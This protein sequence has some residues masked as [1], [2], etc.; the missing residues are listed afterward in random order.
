MDGLQ[1]CQ[2][3][4]MKKTLHDRHIPIIILTGDKTDLVHQAAIQVGAF[5]V[6]AKPVSAPTLREA[7]SAS[8]GFQL[9][10]PPVG[11]QLTD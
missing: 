8:V 4:R 7:I 10:E 9:A 1:F 3:I 2:R 6:L 5:T 11:F